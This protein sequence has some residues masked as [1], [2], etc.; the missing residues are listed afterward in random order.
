MVRCDSLRIHEPGAD[1]Q[2]GKRLVGMIPVKKVTSAGEALAARL[3]GHLAPGRDM[4]IEDSIP[5]AQER[6]PGIA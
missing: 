2:R 3:P 5:A 1:P 4:E 6:Q